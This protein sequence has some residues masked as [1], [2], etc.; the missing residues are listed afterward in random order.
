MTDIDALIAEARDWQSRYASWPVT[1]GTN[2]L[3]GR[4][5]D[6]LTA[7]RAKLTALQAVAHDLLKA[8]N[9]EYTKRTSLQAAAPDLLEALNTERAKV[10]SLEA[11]VERLNKCLIYEQHRFGRQGTH[12]RGCHAGGP[13]HYECLKVE[14]DRWREVAGECAGALEEAFQHGEIMTSERRMNRCGVALTAYRA[15]MESDHD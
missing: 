13:E 7:E 10:A 3:I 9:A 14:A 6:A 5:L 1:A 12:W 8:V 4:L 11:E 15:A 2:V